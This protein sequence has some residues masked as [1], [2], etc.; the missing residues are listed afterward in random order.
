MR[1]RELS[2]V[3]LESL[4]GLSVAAV[5]IVGG[6]QVMHGTLDWPQLLA[7]L[8][9]VRAMHGPLDHINADLMPIQRHGAAAARIQSLLQERPEAVDARRGAAAGGGAAAYRAGR[10]LVQL[11][12]SPRARRPLL[13]ARAG[14]T[15]GIAGPSGS[16]K[17]TLLGLVA[18]FYDP[19]DGAVRFDGTDLRRVRLHD[20]RRQI[21]AVT[22]EPF[23][24]ETNVRENIRCGRPAASDAEVEAAAR[25]ADDPRRDPLPCRRATTPCSASAGAVSPAARRNAS[26]SRAR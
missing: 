16:G 2:N 26:T 5:I 23:L 7:F 10:R 20:L 1:I 15:L 14:E 3:V 4:A 11:R 19:S 6:L 22:Q 17:T 8:M 9:A 18:R 21:A 12:R 25:S 13:R 24:F